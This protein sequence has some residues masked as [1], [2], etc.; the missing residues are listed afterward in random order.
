MNMEAKNLR[1]VR[2]AHFTAK[3]SSIVLT[4]KSKDIWQIKNQ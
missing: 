2:Y 4:N 1:I 3:Q